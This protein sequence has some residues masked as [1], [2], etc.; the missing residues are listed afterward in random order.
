MTDND[1]NAQQKK[2]SG[3]Q[4][5]LLAEDN[6]QVRTLAE[7]VLTQNGYRVI[8]AENGLKALNLF[9]EGHLHVN[10]LLTDLNMP[11]LKGTELYSKLK[12]FDQ[13]LKVI[14]MSG[15]PDDILGCDNVAD[16]SVFFVQKPFSIKSLLSKVQEA[17]SS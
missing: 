5:I 2:A 6:D 15:Y 8:T 7:I 4:S 16:P 13:D 11:E 10:L 9:T 12:E 17:L 14:Y 1:L 3:V